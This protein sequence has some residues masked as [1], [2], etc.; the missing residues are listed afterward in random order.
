MY[1]NILDIK[2]TLK[3]RKNASHASRQGA[4]SS[5]QAG[6]ADILSL[7]ITGIAFAFIA[8]LLVYVVYCS[9]YANFFNGFKCPQII[10]WSTGCMYFTGSGSDPGFVKLI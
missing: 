1:T 8:R 6:M 9:K 10:S 2:T 3:E 5:T 7:R 4:E